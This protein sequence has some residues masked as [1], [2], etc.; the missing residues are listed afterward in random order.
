MHPPL[1]ASIC[2]S[3]A[4]AKESGD[5][6]A[7]VQ[8][9][10][11]PFSQIACFKNAFRVAAGV[12]ARQL[13]QQRRL[14]SAISAQTSLGVLR[15]SRRG[16]RSESHAVFRPTSDSGS[17]LMTGAAQSSTP[18][19]TW[20]TSVS[21]KQCAVLRGGA[22]SGGMDVPVGWRRAE[23]AESNGGCRQRGMVPLG[24]WLRRFATYVATL[25]KFRAQFA[26]LEGHIMQPS[27]RCLQRLTSAPWQLFPH[28]LLQGLVSIG[29]SLESVDLQLVAA[30]CSIRA[31]TSSAAYEPA[32]QEISAVDFDMQAF[33][34]HPF[35]FWVD[36]NLLCTPA[37]LRGRVLRVPGIVAALF[38]SPPEA[39]V[40]RLLRD[41][42]DREGKA[43]AL[44]RRRA[45][46]W[47]DDADVERFTASF[48][49]ALRR[50]DMPKAV[51]CRVL[52]TMVNGSVASRCA[53]STASS[54]CN[55]LDGFILPM[56]RL[57]LE[58]NLMAVRARGV[59][60]TL[61]CVGVAG[62]RG[63][64]VALHLDA[65]LMAYSRLRHGH[66]GD[67]CGS[68]AA[69]LKEVSRRHPAAT[70]VIRRCAAERVLSARAQGVGR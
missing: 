31:N 44:L 25:P 36:S 22:G 1:A 13:S 48:V 39:S 28:D 67:A 38:E 59:V 49:E 56:A 32:L 65:A 11:D 66:A 9:F 14:P 21:G 10:L 64:R 30:A 7:S 63:F 33:L 42:V 69:R 15:A 51:R 47:V 40:L 17:P 54:Y 12:A 60:G 41:G 43:L 29:F 52:R 6:L 19:V 35:Q 46:R 23:N 57:H 68:Y 53:R 62:D 37:R 18:S 16:T 34:I 26:D 20:S 24:A 2:R 70:A 3:E 50:R 4:F 8:S 5:L 27:R 55:G 61:C 58:L 45:R